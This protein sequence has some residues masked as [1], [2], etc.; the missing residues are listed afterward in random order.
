MKKICCPIFVPGNRRNMLEKA[1]GF[2][3]DFIVPDLED[4]V[5]A[6][7]KKVARELVSDAA[8]EI[9]NNGQQVMVRI[10]AFD[11]G[12]A[13]DDINAVVM[14]AVK[15]ISVGK[16]NSVEDVDRYANLLDVSENAKGMT[17]GS[18]KIVLWIESALAIQHAFGIANRSDRVIAV[19]FGG[20]DYT[21]NMGVQRSHNSE[22]LRYPRSVLGVA[23]RAA[24]VIALDTPYVNF[25]DNS[26]L[27]SE[28]KD[29]IKLGFKGKF[30]IH[31]NQIETI[32]RGFGPTIDDIK[33]AVRIVEKWNEMSAKGH[34][35]FD[36]DG[37]MIDVPVVERARGLINEAEQ[38]GLV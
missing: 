26:G 33:K 12:L 17:I 1:L 3:T 34:G 19:A 2:D 38:I 13:E 36:M 21:L 35:S 22:E 18:T 24:G 32:K 10:N 4:S 14:D 15:A 6:N 23:A 5:P 20:E 16:I 7:E 31:P 8:P 25:K 37:E 28:I 9:A 29:V 11:T 27:E 30:A